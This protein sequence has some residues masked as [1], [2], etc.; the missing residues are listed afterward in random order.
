MAA[1]RFEFEVD[2]VAIGDDPAL[3]L[4]AAE[5]V[6]QGGGLESSVAYLQVVVGTTRMGLQL[7]A[8]HVE[9]NL[10]A[11]RSRDDPDALGVV[12]IVVWPAR[13]SE[14]SAQS[15]KVAATHWTTERVKV[16][17]DDT[18]GSFFHR[19]SYYGKLSKSRKPE[20]LKA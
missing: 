8:S 17:R 15:E 1:V 20:F 5:P 13:R 2:G 9:S 18:P 4:V 12:R 16:I 7:E 10:V 6:E 19:F 11:G 14:D 3:D